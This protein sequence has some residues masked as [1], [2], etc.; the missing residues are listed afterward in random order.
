[1]SHGEM[2]NQAQRRVTKTSPSEEGL[3][4][5]EQGS[6]SGMDTACTS[7]GFSPCVPV[8]V[9][10]ISLI[11]TIQLST[12]EKGCALLGK[13]CALMGRVKSLRVLAAPTKSTALGRD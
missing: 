10:A 7:S 3:G 11:S 1:M 8:A 13:A 4:G 9:H 2:L 6:V 5:A 12:N